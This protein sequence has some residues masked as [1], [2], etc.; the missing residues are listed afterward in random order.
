[1]DP[2]HELFSGD[3]KK[4][5]CKTKLE[6]LPELDLDEAVFLR[7]KSY[8]LIIKQ[9]SSHCKHKEMQDQKKYTL[10]YKYCLG[11]LKINM[12]LTFFRSNKPE[13]T[14]VKQKKKL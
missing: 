7:S 13:I 14:K 10:D 8:S 2:S 3:N 9:N 5:I 11:K 6:T 4:V 12:V 1:M